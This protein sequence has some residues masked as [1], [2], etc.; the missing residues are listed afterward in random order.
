KTHTYG[1]ANTLKDAGLTSST[2]EAIRLI[3]QG[4]VKLDSEK[5]SDTKLEIAAGKQYII[6]VGK[7]KFAKVKLSQ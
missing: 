1:I 4:A 3:N 6:Q 7:R 2:S 5:I